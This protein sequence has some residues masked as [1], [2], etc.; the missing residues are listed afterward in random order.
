MRSFEV[1]GS[2]GPVKFFI[3]SEACREPNIPAAG[4][5]IGNIFLAGGRFGNIHFRH[6]VIFGI[7]VVIW[8]CQLSTAA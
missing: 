3:A 4:P 8:P 6:G 7:M 1:N 2:P 5:I